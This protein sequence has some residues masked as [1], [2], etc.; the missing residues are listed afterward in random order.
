ME[1]NRTQFNS[2]KFLK[3]LWNTIK[4]VPLES[5]KAT[6]DHTGSRAA[7][8]VAILRMNPNPF[9]DKVTSIDEFLKRK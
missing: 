7:S 2:I 9:K 8:V 6:S 5:T 1:D 4:E 3:E